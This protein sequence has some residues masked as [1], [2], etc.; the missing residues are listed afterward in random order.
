MKEFEA[1]FNQAVT[2]LTEYVICVTKD[3][4]FVV[5]DKTTNNYE[6]FKAETKQNGYITVS[7]EGCETSIYGNSY[8]NILARVWHDKIHLEFDLDF[9]EHGET[10]VANIQQLEVRQ[11]IGA[12]YNEDR[13]YY[14][15]LLIWLDIYEQVIYYKETGKF[16]ENQL[17][18][19]K[20]RF[21]E[22]VR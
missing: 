4:K 22:C 6:V 9:S 18:F 1:I 11:F 21:M 15:G 19:I 10:I 17:E 5:A 14:A 16:V 12:K 3:D 2:D 8:I 20:N 7:S 13:G